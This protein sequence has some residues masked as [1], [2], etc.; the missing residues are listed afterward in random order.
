[1]KKYGILEEILRKEFGTMGVFSR[2]SGIPRSTLS[3][4]ISGKYGS[5]ERGIQKRLEEKLRY[6]RP[7]IDVS[8]IWDPAHAWH[9]RYIQSRDIVKNGFRIIVDV[10]LDDEGRL[11]IAPFVEGY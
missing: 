10:K 4:L 3:M 11:T 5:D 7:E 2:E 6:L 9:E 8:H 1:M